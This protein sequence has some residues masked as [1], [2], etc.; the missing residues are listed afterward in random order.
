MKWRALILGG[1]GS[2]GEFQIGALKVISEKFDKFDF[3]VGLGCGSLN[4]TMLAQSETVSDAY[5]IIDTVWS[6]I[7]KTSD[8]LDVPFLGTAAGFIGAM[9]TDESWGRQSV[10]GNKKLGTIIDEHIDWDIL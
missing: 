3:Y 9:M 6:N 4:G 10:Y 7:K 2:I 1:G 5:S 8:I